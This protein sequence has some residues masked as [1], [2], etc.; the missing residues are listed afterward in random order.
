[1]TFKLDQEPFSKVIIFQILLFFLIER[2]DKSDS[3]NSNNFKRIQNNLKNE[4]NLVFV[5]KAK[6]WFKLKCL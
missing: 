3:L 1:M 2:L 5:K 6:I 4:L